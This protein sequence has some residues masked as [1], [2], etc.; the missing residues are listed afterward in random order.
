MKITK[1]K[2]KIGDIIVYPNR[3][4][5]EGNTMLEFFQSKI[6]S[7]NCLW[8]TGDKFD[9]PSWYYITEHSDEN[10]EDFLTDDDILF[11]L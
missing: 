3:Y 5:Q 8:E 6:I 7:S 11:K 10:E 4:Q 2:Y 9:K 1:P